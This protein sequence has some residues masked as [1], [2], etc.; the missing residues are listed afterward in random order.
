[1]QVPAAA[2]GLQR[3]ITL[4]RA[5]A[6]S[7]ANC[8]L[9]G[10]HRHTHDGQEQQ[11]EQHKHTAAILTRHVGEFPHVADADGAAGTYQNE[12]QPGLKAFSFHCFSLLFVS[13]HA[14]REQVG[15][16]PL[17]SQFWAVNILLSLPQNV[18]PLFV[19]SFKA[20]C[21]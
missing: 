13:E 6:A 5:L 12:A 14:K 17:R 11:V 16:K 4:H 10:Q 7:T 19:Y 2:L 15:P 3:L 1:M 21:F 18:N 20:V 9:H 8:Q